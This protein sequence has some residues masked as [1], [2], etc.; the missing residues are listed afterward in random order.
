MDIPRGQSIRGRDSK[1]SFPQLSV[2]AASDSRLGNAD[3][4]AS[5]G[6]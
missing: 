1:G 6:E 5:P 3:S 2:I 4:I